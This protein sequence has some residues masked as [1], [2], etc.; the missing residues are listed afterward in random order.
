MP[1]YSFSVGMI[2]FYCNFQLA[3]IKIHKSIIDN[4]AFE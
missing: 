4:Y 3:F 1:P 2:V